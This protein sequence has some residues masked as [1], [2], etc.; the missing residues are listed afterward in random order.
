MAQIDVSDLLI[1]PDFTDTVTLIRRASSVNGFGEHVIVETPSTIIA[2]VETGD[3]DALERMPDAARLTDLITVYYKGILFAESPSGY[4]DVIVW[5][6]NRYQVKDVPQQ[7]QNYG[8]GFT[9]AICLL[10]SATIAA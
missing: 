3:Q 6:G 4:A 7:Y 10:E 5:Q 1:D 9:Q 8:A 2:V